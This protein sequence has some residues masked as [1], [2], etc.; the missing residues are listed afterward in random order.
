MN[1]NVVHFE[2]SVFIFIKLKYFYGSFLLTY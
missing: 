1:K 2:Q